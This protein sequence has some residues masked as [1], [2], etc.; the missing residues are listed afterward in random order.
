MAR[1]E[2]RQSQVDPRVRGGDLANRRGKTRPSGRSPRARGRPICKSSASSISRSI[3]ACAGETLCRL[4]SP[5][6]CW[7]DPRVRGGDTSAYAR[8]PHLAGRSPRA[9]GR[10]AALAAAYPGV[11]SIPACAGETAP[12]WFTP[13]KLKV[14]PR[15]RGGDASAYGH[16]AFSMGRSPRARGRRSNQRRPTSGVGSIPACA[17]ETFVVTNTAADPEVDPRV[18]GGDRNS[19]PPQATVQGRS[20]RARGRRSHHPS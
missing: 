19:P 3:P 7:V 18:R 20:P 14:D 17:G 9:R 2:W 1:A 6:Q 11:G 8:D 16:A 10:L 13:C 12:I 5:Q 15:V 4:L